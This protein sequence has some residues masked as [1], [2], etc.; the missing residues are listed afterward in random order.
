MKLKLGISS[1]SYQPIYQAE[2]LQENPGGRVESISRAVT[3]MLENL[4]I[5]YSRI[6]QN[7]YLLF[8]TIPSRVYNNRRGGE[9]LTAIGTPNTLR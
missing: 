5:I 3:I 9:C 7:L 4:P 1:Y 6:S 2:L 8:L